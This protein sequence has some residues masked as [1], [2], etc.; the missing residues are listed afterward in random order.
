MT[1]SWPQQANKQMFAS[2]RPNIYLTNGRWSETE[3]I[4]LPHV[5]LTVEMTYSWPKQ[6]CQ[7]T[8]N[9]TNTNLTYNRWLKW[10]FTTSNTANVT[11]YRWLMYDLNKQPTNF[12]FKQNQHWLD[13]QQMDWNWQQLSDTNNY[14]YLTLLWL[15]YSYL[16]KPTYKEN[17][18][19]LYII[20]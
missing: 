4:W 6:T 11:P 2:S 5:T 12:N 3:N 8:S 13:Y 15:I 18:H 19:K 16:N 17:Q 14:L 10:H 20:L 1:F 9:R 7:Q